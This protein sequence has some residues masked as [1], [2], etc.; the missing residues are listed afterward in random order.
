ME[1]KKPRTCRRQQFRQ[2]AEIT[3]HSNDKKATAVHFRINIPAPFLDEILQNMKFMFD[4]S[5]AVV[6]VGFKLIPSGAISEPNLIITLQPFLHMYA[7]DLPARHTLNAKID[8]W[9]QKW[10]NRWSQ[11]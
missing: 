6:V 10:T 1:V 11:K 9:V 4:K 5:Q 3:V 2:N 7:D 8:M